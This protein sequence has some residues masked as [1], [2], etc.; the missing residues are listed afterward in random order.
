ME[1]V[2]STARIQVLA[3]CVLCTVIEA[4]V[5]AL[6]NWQFVTANTEYDVFEFVGDNSWHYHNYQKRK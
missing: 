6:W 4:P 5:S 1:M 2:Q 3:I